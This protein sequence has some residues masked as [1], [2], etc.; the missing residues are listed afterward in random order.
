[1]R[2]RRQEV[3]LSVLLYLVQRSYRACLRPGEQTEERAAKNAEPAPR[4]TASFR[5]PDAHPVMEVGRDGMM[6]EEGPFS[7][8][9]GPQ[10]SP[11]ARFLHLS[12]LNDRLTDC[13]IL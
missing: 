4:A 10:A 6:F 5:H 2:A 3:E 7:L 11:T 12:L 1:M 8:P 13:V 9:P